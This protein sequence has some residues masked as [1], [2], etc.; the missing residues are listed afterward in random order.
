MVKE[1]KEGREGGRVKATLA[2][3]LTP[4][5]SHKKASEVTIEISRCHTQERT[6]SCSG[7]KRRNLHFA[8]TLILLM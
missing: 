2:E 6:S 3:S 4:I 1:K 8:Y 7:V 5:Y